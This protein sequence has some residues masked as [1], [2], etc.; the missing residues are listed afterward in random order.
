MYIVV[1]EKVWED[2]YIYSYED[3]LEAARE[4]QESLVSELFKQVRIYKVEDEG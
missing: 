4:K 2:D 1:V 3:T